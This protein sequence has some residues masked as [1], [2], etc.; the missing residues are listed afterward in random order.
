MIE[1]EKVQ[2]RNIAL[3]AVLGLMTG[4]SGIVRGSGN[5]AAFEAGFKTI[6]NGLALE[7][8]RQWKHL[9]A[10]Q[11]TTITA[12]GLAGLIL[13]GIGLCLGLD[14]IVAQATSSWLTVVI[15]SAGEIYRRIYRRI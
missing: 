3:A 1:L 11:K 7:G 8:I 5:E 14:P 15:G 2:K 4:I 10:E 12:A 9:L 13:G 6:Y